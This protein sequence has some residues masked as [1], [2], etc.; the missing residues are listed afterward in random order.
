VPVTAATEVAGDPM[1]IGQAVLDDAVV[2]AT[3]RAAAPAARL[4]VSRDRALALVGLL[5]LG[6]AFAVAVRPPR[7]SRAEA[8]GAPPRRGPALRVAPHRGPPAGLARP[9]GT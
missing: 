9:S 2:P 5:V 4:L 6:A 1:E 8:R 3:M 7:L